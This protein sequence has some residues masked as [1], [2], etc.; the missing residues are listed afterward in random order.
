MPG[1]FDGSYVNSNDLELQNSFQNGNFFPLK[2]L[3]SYMLIDRG[4]SLV[5]YGHCRWALL[6]PLK[7]EQVMFNS[8]VE[9]RSQ[10]TWHPVIPGERTLSLVLNP[11][12][13]SPES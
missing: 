3:L 10:L 1:S 12:R 8:D 2:P 9:L 11:A 4:E 6:G 13:K 7:E 5:G